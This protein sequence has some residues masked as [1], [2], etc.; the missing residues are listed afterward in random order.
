MYREV[1]LIEDGNFS[2]TYHVK[3]KI[4]VKVPRNRPE[5]PVRE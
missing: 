4:K 1:Y 3:V 5:G 2:L